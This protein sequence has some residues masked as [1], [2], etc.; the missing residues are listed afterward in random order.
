[1]IQLARRMQN[2]IFIQGNHDSMYLPYLNCK[3]DEASYY[4]SFGSK[5]TV[6][7]YFEK[8]G[9]YAYIRF[10]E[11][12]TWLASL[13]LYVKEENY[14]FCHAGFNPAKPIADQRDELLWGCDEFFSWK[15]PENQLVLFGHYRAV[16]FRGDGIF[17]PWIAPGKICLNTSADEGGN[18]SLLE[19]PSGI[20]YSTPC[21]TTNFPVP[22]P[23]SVYPGVIT[24]SKLW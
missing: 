2:S 6:L 24:I 18:L 5:V 1:M 19:L 15:P 9:P 17:S 13:P 14:I 3:I 12:A 4:K 11:D 21:I 16:Y 20:L 10:Q 7:S 23:E 8:Y 22:R